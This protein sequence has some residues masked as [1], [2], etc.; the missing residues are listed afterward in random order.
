FLEFDDALRE[1]FF[2]RFQ[3]GDFGGIGGQLRHQLFNSRFAGSIHRI[4]ESEPSGRVNRLSLRA[5]NQRPGSAAQDGGPLHR[6]RCRR[7][8]CALE[9]GERLLVNTKASRLEKFEL[10][11]STGAA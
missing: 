5:F 4:L 2:L 10:C 6:Y 11:P 7:E 1:R 9:I 3:R 8:A